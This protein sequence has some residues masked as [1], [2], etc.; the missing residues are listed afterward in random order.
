MQKGW[1]LSFVYSLIE[2]RDVYIVIK[3]NGH[4][5]VTYK[6]FSNKYLRGKIPYYKK[7]WDEKGRRYLEIRNALVNFGLLNAKTLE[8]IGDYFNVDTLPGSPLTLHDEII[9]KQIYFRYFR[10]KEMTSLL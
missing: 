10:F 3:K 8:C 5:G 2:L 7:E 1:T 4:N 6:D 9:F